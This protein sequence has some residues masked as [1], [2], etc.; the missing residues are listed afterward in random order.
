MNER[1]MIADL[2]AAIQA[3]DT[4]LVCYRIGDSPSE[5]LWN[6]LSKAQKAI[7]KAIEHLATPTTEPK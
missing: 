5:A 2:I 4:L 6:R 7:D 1:K 3:K